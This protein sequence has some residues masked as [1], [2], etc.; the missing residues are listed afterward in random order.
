METML[1][2]PYIDVF[3]S[4]VRDNKIAQVALICVFV[5]IILDWA[6]GITNAIQHKEF[7][8]TKMRE[9][10]YHKTA[11]VGLLFVGI[12]IDGA[13]LGGFD[14]GYSAPVFTAICVYICIME[15]GSL[16]EIFASMNPELQN[17]PI[18]AMLDSVNDTEGRHTKDE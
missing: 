13:L 6:F 4:V 2:P 10:L 9:G 11:E 1:F 14:F 17:S 15:V 16:L 5:F 7:S 18:F 3:L 8:S 12:M